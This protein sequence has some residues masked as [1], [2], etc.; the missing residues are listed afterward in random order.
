MYNLIVLLELL[1]EVRL[2]ASLEDENIARVLAVSTA[3]GRRRPPSPPL[4]PPGLHRINMSAGH[5]K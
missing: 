3:S 4:P 2:L 1:R 5:R